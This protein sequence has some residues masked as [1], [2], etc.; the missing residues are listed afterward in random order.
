MEDLLAWSVSRARVRFCLREAGHQKAREKLYKA[1]VEAWWGEAVAWL[2]IFLKS[3]GKKI[4]LY[5]KIFLLVNF[6]SLKCC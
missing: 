4:F 2:K 3:V 1:R 5:K 6:F